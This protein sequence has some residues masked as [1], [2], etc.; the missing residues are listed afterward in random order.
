M[1]KKHL[2]YLQKKIEMQKDIWMQIH[3]VK[4]LTVVKTPIYL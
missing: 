2:A 4:R 3:E 1:K